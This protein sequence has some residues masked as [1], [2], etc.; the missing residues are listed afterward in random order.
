[1]F[2]EAHHFTVVDSTFNTVSGNY[3]VNNYG[4]IEKEQISPEQR[5]KELEKIREWLKPSDPSQN[6]NEHIEDQVAGTGEWFLNGEEYK[7][8][9]ETP[10]SMMWLQG[11]MGCGKSVL[12]SGVIKNLKEFCSNKAG[13][14]IAYYFFDFRN[15]SKQD[16]KDLVASLLIQLCS[17][18]NSA[19]K[20]YD[21]LTQ[22]HKNHKSG[23]SEAGLTALKSALIDV[24]SLPTWSCL[25][26][27]IDALDEMEGKSFETFL[28]LVENLHYE[29][30]QHV[31]ILS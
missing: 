12:I 14:A 25:F 2:S 19:P 31:H 30:I 26:I 1:M 6:Y 22:M 5:E 23:M 29:G 15:A 3:T 9:K 7:K 4:K 18:I 28:K 8:W 27:V 21:I 24:T 10:N 11:E 17:D 20:A 13:A 16:T